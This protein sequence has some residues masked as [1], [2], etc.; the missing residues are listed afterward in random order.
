MQ[1]SFPGLSRGQSIAL[2]ATAIVGLGLVIAGAPLLF[3]GALGVLILVSF[4]VWK[5]TLGV[6]AMCIVLPLI[7]WEFSIATLYFTPI[8]LIALLAVLSLFTRA[9]WTRVFGNNPQPLRWPFWKVFLAFFIVVIISNFLNPGLFSSL[10]YGL[11]VVIFLYF[12]YIVLPASVIEDKRQLRTALSCIAV[13]GAAVAILSLATLYGQFIDAEFFRIRGIRLFGIYPFGANHNLIAE[14]LIV[15][16]FCLLALKYWCEPGAWR[17]AITIIFSIFAVVSLATFS[18][19]AWIAIGV[20]LAVF[21]FYRRTNRVKLLIA[22]LALAILCTPL[23][24]KMSDLQSYNTS[25]TAS[26]VLLTQIAE[27]SVLEKPL[28]GFGSGNFINIIRKN[29]RFNAQ[30]GEPLESHGMIQK[31]AVEHGIIGIAIFMLII[32]L[33][34]R[35]L[36]SSRFMEGKARDLILPL[37][38]ASLGGFVFQV[39]NTSYYKGKLWLPVGL[40]LVAANLVMME[41]KKHVS[42]KN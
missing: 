5:P 8:D 36:F 6:Y 20:Q 3:L 39:F 1:K 40:A 25:S 26:R 28:F 18:R 35:R 14:Y 27:A 9:S 30:Y 34:F 22:T 19:A 12:A 13:S 24:L 32:L 7:G 17:R 4:F 2:V 38:V 37:A 33:I 21:F 41:K 16:N 11:R 23:V 10:W 29:I 42:A 31:V 15:T